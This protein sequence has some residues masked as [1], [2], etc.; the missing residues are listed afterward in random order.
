MAAMTKPLRGTLFAIP[1]GFVWSNG[2]RRAVHGFR[3]LTVQVAFS[4]TTG[5]VAVRDVAELGIENA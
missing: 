4:F 3:G 1:R 5:N 2:W